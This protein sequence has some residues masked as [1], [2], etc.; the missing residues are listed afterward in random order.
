MRYVAGFL[1]VLA[2]LVAMSPTVVRAADP[3]ADA[4]MTLLGEEGLSRLLDRVQA[5]LSEVMTIRAAFVQ[6]KHLRVLEQVV[7]VEGLFLFEAPDRVRLETCSP[8][9]SA[10]VASGGETR[11][12]EEVGGH[13]TA[14]TGGNTDV[15]RLAM[16]Q[17]AAWVR[18]DLRSASGAFDLAATGESPP[19]FCLTPVS[20]RLGRYIK[21]IRLTLAEDPMRMVCIEIEEPSGDFTRMRFSDEER[22]LQLPDTVFDASVPCDCSRAKAHPIPGS[23]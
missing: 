1:C 2:W 15:S 19:S 11:A 16:A 12:Y 21:A 3:A 8:Y 14:L 22:N 7:R 5:G 13:W 18:G 23:Q 6:E 10:L 20:G 9:R 4:P 17:V